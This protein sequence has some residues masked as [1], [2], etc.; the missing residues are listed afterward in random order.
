MG[1]YRNRGRQAPDR[2]CSSWAR[3]R[4]LSDWHD[5]PAGMEEDDKSKER[6]KMREREWGENCRGGEEINE[7]PNIRHLPPPASQIRLLASDMENEIPHMQSYNIRPPADSYWLLKCCA[8]SLR[9]ITRRERLFK[10]SYLGVEKG[11]EDN[12][13]DVNNS[14]YGPILFI[15][16]NTKGRFYCFF[17]VLDVPIIYIQFSCVF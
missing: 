4:P 13:A 7:K 3:A 12:M 16:F 2:S 10:A 8:S 9:I 11:G 14:D 1:L 15:L 5:G 17:I 6:R